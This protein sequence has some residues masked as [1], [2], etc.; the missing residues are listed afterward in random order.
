MDKSNG[1]A[2]CI[3][4]LLLTIGGCTSYKGHKL[5]ENGA[6]PKDKTTGIPFV[7]TKPMYSVDIT[8][9]ASD[10][11]KPIYTLRSIDVP[12]ATQ[13]YTIALD[14]ALLVDGTYDLSF[15]EQGNIISASATNNSRV[16]ATLDSFVSAS[17][18]LAAK[19]VGKDITSVLALYRQLVTDSVDAACTKTTNGELVKL[20]IANHINDLTSDAR[21]EIKDS[22]Q[23]SEKTAS[24]LA[25]SRY[26]YLNLAQRNCLIAVEPASATHLNINV[27][28]AK[29]NF[30]TALKNAK[31]SSLDK[32]SKNWLLSIESAVKDSDLEQI[33]RLKK[34]SISEALKSITSPAMIYVNESID[35]KS[36]KQLGELFAYM[37]PD[38]WRARHLQY[39]ESQISKKRL[40]N[41]VAGAR[42]AQSS[43]ITR[44]E[45]EWAATL[46]EP[47]LINRIDE[48]DSFL[49]E[50]RVVPAGP[51]NSA[52]YAATEFI[53]LREERDKLQERV[54]GLRTNVLSKNKLIDADPAKKKVVPRT[55]VNVKLVRSSFID[56]VADNPGAFTDLP[57]F[58][59]V[60]GSLSEPVLLPDPS[61]PNNPPAAANTGSK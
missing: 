28:K 41:L 60:V 43:D 36:L 1:R 38:I 40:E 53:Q 13:R 20:Q 27:V 39:L 33:E 50:V 46:G 15:G 23:N 12:D 29:N 4:L 45:S 7:M 22:E 6:L 59:L 11:T 17:I 26:H 14:P 10:A 30:D 24:A 16:V 61:T 19:G 58:V 21:I 49:S 31:S 32:P 55:D 51:G 42:G 48:L 9:D 56:A 47:K 3:A 18:D 52:R 57:E 2:V 25:A 5:P 37:T 54:D 35:S 8:A 44:L 34:A